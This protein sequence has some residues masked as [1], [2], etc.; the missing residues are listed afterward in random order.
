MKYW[1]IILSV[2]YLLSPIDLLPERVFGRLGLIDDFL[3]AGTMYWYYFLRPAAGR[4]RARVG[5]EKTEKSAGE[6][7]A[8]DPYSI[9]GLSKN[10]SPEEIKHAYRE[11]ANKYHP[12]KV[13][14]LGEEFREIAHR[15]FKEIRR[16][17][18]QLAPK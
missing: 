8:G 2:I 7:P 6:E 11:L 1:A 17:Y 4:A 5:G 15:K 9:L 3:I 14:H 16:A 13:S 18:E 10:A 12:D